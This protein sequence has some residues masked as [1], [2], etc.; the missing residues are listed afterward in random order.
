MKT[1]Y[2][3]KVDYIDLIKRKPDI[4][5]IVDFHDLDEALE[6]ISSIRLLSFN[7]ITIIKRFIT[8]TEENN[9]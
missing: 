5:E 6:F 4:K 1:V 2:D 8:T 7:S 3:L 9:Q